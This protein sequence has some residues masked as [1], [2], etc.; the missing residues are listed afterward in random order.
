MA[1][2]APSAP[3]EL[4]YFVAAGHPRT[5][6]GQVQAFVPGFLL[7]MAGLVIA[8][9]W[10]TM[11]AARLMARR[12]RRPASLIAARRLADSPRAGFR[13]VSGLVIA[14][15]VTTVAV[16]VITTRVANRGA[17]SGSAAASDTLTAQLGYG[18]GE[19]AVRQRATRLL[20]PVAGSRVLRHRARRAR[21]LSRDHRLHLPGAG[22]DHRAGN[23]PQRVAGRRTRLARDTGAALAGS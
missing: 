5:T 4:T 15:F 23:R 10:L 13:A 11:V 8:G 9:P 16:G 6:G 14:L 3:A 1:P 22:P 12:A 2:T 20:A 19:A 17:P 18:Q 21:R 7:I